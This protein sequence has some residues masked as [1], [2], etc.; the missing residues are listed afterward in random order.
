[1]V[2]RSRFQ[3]FA[4]RLLPAGSTKCVIRSRYDLLLSVAIVLGPAAR[5][6]TFQVAPSVCPAPR[7]RAGEPFAVLVCGREIPLAPRLTPID[8]AAPDEAAWVER[9]LAQFS[10][11]S[12]ARL[13]PGEG[14]APPMAA[15]RKSKDN[16]WLNGVCFA[17]HWHS[18]MLD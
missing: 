11:G 6:R 2:E 18:H 17:G 16:T 4:A 8:G 10:G 13:R 7:L 3:T 5:V 15:P 12:D 1:M 14:D 9:L